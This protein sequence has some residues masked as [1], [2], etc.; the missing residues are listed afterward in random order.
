MLTVRRFTMLA[1][2]V[3]LAA[4]GLFIIAGLS[5]CA[6][7]RHTS[8]DGEETCFRSCLMSAQATAIA[9]KT[10]KAGTNY[11]RAVE[12]GSLAGQSEVEKLAPIAERIAAAAT[13]GAVSALGKAATP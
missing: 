6:S 7:Y 13:A 9:S 3:A 12:V 4:V 2:L 5:G 11:T 1:I 8:P 10:T